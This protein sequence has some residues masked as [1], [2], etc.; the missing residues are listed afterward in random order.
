MS[1]KSRRKQQQIRDQ[2]PDAAGFECLE[3]IKTHLARLTP[4]QRAVG[5]FIIKNPE[6]LAFLSIVELAGKAGVSQATVVRFSNALGYD[7]Y[8]QL[9]G[10]IRQAI[11][12]AY[13]SLDRFRLGSSIK[14]DPSHDRD[15]S[16]FSRVLTSEIDN[17]IA[18]T[19]NLK[20]SDFY[21]CVDRAVAADQIMVMGGFASLSLA[22][23]MQQ[24]LV[25]VRPRVELISQRD[26]TT[27]SRIYGLGKK[28]LVFIVSFPRYPK[29]VL[30]LAALA[31]QQK[32][33]IVVITNSPIA[34]P[35]ALADQT[36]FVSVDVP[37]FVD[38]YAAP[39]AFVNALVTEIGMRNPDS[40]RQ[41]LNFY[42]Q[43]AA[44]MGIFFNKKGE[45]RPEDIAGTASANDKGRK[46]TGR[47]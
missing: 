1:Q 26:I 8:T 47:K 33:Y 43:F 12:L 10:E 16:F 46:K 35:V 21:A 38:G 20:S 40:S 24:M 41:A 18:L 23:H 7:G 29:R 2:G 9:S 14:N 17:L 32:A 34:P 6:S 4:R 3:K 30:E 13:G 28:S 22:V 11:Q 25:K 42:D 36:F 15:D 45:W 19:R 5:E 39:M 31:K 44:E 27:S 37:S